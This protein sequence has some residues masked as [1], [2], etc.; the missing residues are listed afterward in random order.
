M[1]KVLTQAEIRTL[2]GFKNNEEAVAFGA[3]IK[4]TNPGRTN[5]RQFTHDEL[6]RYKP[7][8]R[9]VVVESEVQRDFLISVVLSTE[10]LRGSLMTQPEG[11][12]RDAKPIAIW[13][14]GAFPTTPFRMSG[15][16]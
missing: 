6:M 12:Y 15:V 10:C 11:I 2:Y 4:H 13:K 16:L 8:Q 3:R 1:A 5:R 14:K 7:A 9:E